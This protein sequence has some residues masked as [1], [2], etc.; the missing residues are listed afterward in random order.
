LIAERLL[1][2]DKEE[3]PDGQ[4]YFDL[5]EAERVI[6]FFPRYLRHVQAEWAGRP[7]YLDDWQ[8]V[9]IGNIFGWK[10]T[11]TSLRRY[12]EFYLEIPRKN[13]KSTISSGVGIYLAC[14]DGEP[15]ASVCAAA[16][17]EEQARK[18]FDPARQMVKTSAPGLRRRANVGTNSI[19]FPGSF[20]RFF[21]VS[22]DGETLDGENLNGAIVDEIHAHKNRLLLDVIDTAMGARREPLL[23]QI[24]T[25]GR[26]PF[27]VCGEIHDRVI[28][29]QQ[30]LLTE[31]GLYGKIYAADKDKDDPGDP[32]TWAKANPGLGTSIK[33]DY[34]KK[35]WA[36]ALSIPSFYNTFLRLHLN[37]WTNDKESW[38]PVH[39]WKNAQAKEFYSLEDFRGCP[40]WIAVDLSKQVDC[41][42]ATLCFKTPKGKI[43]SKTVLWLPERTYNERLQTE[44]G[45]NWDAWRRE[46]WVNVIPGDVVDY[47]FIYQQLLI[48]KS[49]FEIRRIGFDPWNSLMMQTRCKDEFGPRWV[50]IQMEPIVV[51]F[52]QGYKSMSPAMK[53]LE[54]MIRTHQYEHD[55]NPAMSWMMSNV[56]IDKDPAENIKPNKAKSSNRIDGPVSLIMASALCRNDEDGGSVYND[57]GLI[58]V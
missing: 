42:A 55:G 5:K 39:V 19:S 30:G 2:A 36:K 27:G 56:V 9:D 45:V 51:E 6:N 47:E 11:E 48:W 16:T 20:S 43:R 12:T 50:G 24:T 44:R 53:D 29:I 10:H 54:T 31:E 52:R 57:R 17:T 38:L 21:V 7:M 49:M 41:T 34:L 32:L 23:G 18:V 25:A 37:I 1:P 14:A 22:G 15:G 26:D 40:A 58:A 28:K 33:L 3:T 8:R 35:K 4:F 13:G 46:G